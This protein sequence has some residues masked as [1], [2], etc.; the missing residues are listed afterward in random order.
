MLNGLE[1]GD[2]HLH[3]RALLIFEHNHAVVTHWFLHS[4]TWK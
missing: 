4:M 3:R 1:I 2:W